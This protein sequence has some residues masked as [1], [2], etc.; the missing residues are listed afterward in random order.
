M[1][2]ESQE[3]ENVAERS[4]LPLSPVI[5]SNKRQQNIKPEI[6][7]T[8]HETYIS[9]VLLGLECVRETNPIQ[10]AVSI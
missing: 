7:V 5:T 6:N 3:L 9:P 1:I 10:I 4:V 2:R 8:V